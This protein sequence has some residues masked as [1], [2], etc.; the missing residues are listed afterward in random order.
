MS[1][2]FDF[3]G[4]REYRNGNFGFSNTANFEETHSQTTQLFLRL[5][6]VTVKSLTEFVTHCI[7]ARHS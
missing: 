2:L 7:S 1:V 5:N 3:K 4:Y 6:Y